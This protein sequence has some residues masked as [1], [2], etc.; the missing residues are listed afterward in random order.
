MI[1]DT[2]V[3]IEFLRDGAAEAADA[4]AGRIENGESIVVPETVLMEL[5]SGTTDEVLATQRRRM[6]ES[7]D[8]APL[9]PVVDSLRAARLQR[10][11]RRAGETVR[12]LGDCQIAAV[13]LRRE[14]PVMHRDRDFD[15]LARHCGL[16]T[17]SLL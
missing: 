8:I 10:E 2:S 14:L 16:A 11:C 15:T 12:N 13:A 7:F 1:V 6:L 5:L 3:W 9:E 17:A 4:L